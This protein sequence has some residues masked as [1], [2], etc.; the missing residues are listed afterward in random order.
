MKKVHISVSIPDEL[1]TKLY[2]K[3]GVARHTVYVLASPEFVKKLTELG[4]RCKILYDNSVICYEMVV[5]KEGISKYIFPN[6]VMVKMVSNN[7]NKV[8]YDEQHGNLVMEPS[9]DDLVKAFKEVKDKVEKEIEE[10]LEERRREEERRRI[11]ERLKEYVKKLGVD[12]YGIS[13]YRKSSELEVCEEGVRRL[14]S[15]V[16]ELANKISRLK[17]RVDE[18]EEEVERLREFKEFVV[19]RGLEDE[20][21]EW[22]KEKREE[23]L[24][25]ELREEYLGEE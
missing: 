10:K 2:E 13:V 14:K 19:E 20:F 6:D 24:E 15:K 12:E 8:R 23:E 3:T 11:E 4:F 21:I 16:S 25:E 5:R 17:D 22:L 9:V 7:I 18:L 1:V